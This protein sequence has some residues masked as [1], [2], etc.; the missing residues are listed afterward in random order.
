ME[1]SLFAKLSGELRNRIYELAVIFDHS[2]II[3]SPFRSP[4]HIPRPR[5]TVKDPKADAER[6]WVQ[7]PLL[8]T[9]KQ[10]RSE[11]IGLFYS[12]NNFLVS[13]SSGYDDPSQSFKRDIDYAIWWLKSEEEV[14]RHL[15][16]RLE[17]KITAHWLGWKSDWRERRSLY[18]SLAETLTSCVQN[19]HRFRVVALLL[20]WSLLPPCGEE[21]QALIVSGFEDVGI[22][23]KLV[24]L[25]PYK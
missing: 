4:S 14:N 18:Q 5:F 17:V 6:E 13:V 11:S 15:G 8:R 2:V 22:T 16:Q 25:Y 1:R 20:T 24:N 3:S 9:C 12:Q 23:V 19:S 21:Q 7:P 10:I